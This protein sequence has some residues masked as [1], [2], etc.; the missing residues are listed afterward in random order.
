MHLS[1]VSDVSRVFRRI[2]S[3]FI[4]PKTKA[5]FLAPHLSRLLQNLQNDHAPLL[6]LRC[7]GR[8]ECKLLFSWLFSVAETRSVENLIAAWEQVSLVL[9]FLEP[10]TRASAELP[11][12]SS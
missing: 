8:D 7:F 9:L 11:V 12:K 10:L 5:E 3:F 6:N 4:S 2:I 1:G